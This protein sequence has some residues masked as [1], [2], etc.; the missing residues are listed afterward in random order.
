MPVVMMQEITT[1]RWLRLWL[2]GMERVIPPP[3]G[4]HHYLR[5]AEF[6]SDA[7]GWEKKLCLCVSTS[8][9]SHNFFLE[10]DDMMPERFGITV[11]AI[12]KGL[13]GR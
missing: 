7:A 1:A 9:G 6:G 3:V 4:T 12:R 2:E 8:T 5:F 11:K 13:E 10:D